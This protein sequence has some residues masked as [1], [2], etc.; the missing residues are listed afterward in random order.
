MTGYFFSNHQ[1][2]RLIADG[3]KT[4][5]TL[6]DQN[7]IIK[8]EVYND[9]KLISTT[10]Y[11][12]DSKGRLISKSEDYDNSNTLLTWNDD[13]DLVKIET[14]KVG[15][16]MM[17]DEYS[18][19]ITNGRITGIENHSISEISILGYKSESTTTY[20]YVWKEL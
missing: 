6:N 1:I 11:E 7:L 20:T 5:Y 10:I 4:E 15:G 13:D 9:D 2:T 8:S 19:T 16:D 14:G 3:L 18:Y 17:T 12:Y